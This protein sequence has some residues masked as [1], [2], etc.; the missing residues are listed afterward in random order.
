MTLEYVI[1][2]THGH[3]RTC[4]PTFYTVNQYNSGRNCWYFFCFFQ[5]FFPYTVFPAFFSWV[6][7][8]AGPTTLNFSVGVLAFQ[9][10]LLSEL[11]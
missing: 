1:K 4:A 3:S 9:L 6:H 5:R 7:G 10:F 11:Y 2:V 8:G